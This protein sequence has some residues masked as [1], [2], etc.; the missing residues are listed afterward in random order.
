MTIR[1]EYLEFVLHARHKKKFRSHIM[2][3]K[4]RS[5]CRLHVLINAVLLIFASGEFIINE[6]EC[7]I[8][9]SGHCPTPPS[10]ELFH[11]SNILYFHMAE[12]N[13]VC[14][15]TSSDGNVCGVSR[16]LLVTARCLVVHNITRF[17]LNLINLSGLPDKINVVYGFVAREL[18]GI[19]IA[20]GCFRLPVFVDTGD[21]FGYPFLYTM[22]P[23]LSLI[24]KLRHQIDLILLGNDRVFARDIPVFVYDHLS[25]VYDAYPRDLPEYE[26]RLEPSVDSA[27]CWQRYRS[28]ASFEDS[29]ANCMGIDLVRGKFVLNYAPRGGQLVYLCNAH[30]PCGGNGDRINGMIQVFLLAILLD[31][32]F[33]IDSD[34]PFDLRTVFEPAEWNW[35]TQV[36]MPTVLIDYIDRRKDFANELDVLVAQFGNGNGPPSVGMA[37]NQLLMMTIIEHPNF[38]RLD[39]QPFI[40]SK[41]FQFLFKPRE[42]HL[43]THDKIGIHF[44]AGNM[45]EWN[46]PAR[47]SLGT[48][49]LHFV[50]CAKIIE[51]DLKIDAQFVLA[52]DV[53]LEI[54]IPFLKQFS[55]FVSGKLVV[56]EGLVT[57]TDRTVQLSEQGWFD[58]W[59]TWHALGSMRGLVISRSFFSETAARVG[60]MNAKR[61]RFWKGCVPVDFA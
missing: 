2:N 50:H 12:S 51:K 7:F 16:S 9:C 21:V 55:E 52:T 39:A 45:N 53:H 24:G 1:L 44:R 28:V 59:R 23:I 61:V 30:K 27:T 10:P 48:D 33:V 11:V 8:D 60:R 40:F 36:V 15:S 26:Q 41:F 37:T 56:M 58:S 13:L 32:V 3:S 46:D 18:Q 4:H 38:P 57:H 49:F 22:G 34:Y 35:D 19:D 43:H 42:V 20:N 31:R 6:S 17:I 29:R 14:K 47:H 54:L 5:P 25:F